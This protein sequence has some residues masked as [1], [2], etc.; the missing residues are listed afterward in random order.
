MKTNPLATA[1]TI[2]EPLLDLIVAVIV[3]PVTGLMWIL[4]RA[5]TITVTWPEKPS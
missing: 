5:P 2:S 4:D 1:F 3:S